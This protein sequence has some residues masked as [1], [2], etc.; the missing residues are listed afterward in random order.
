MNRQTLASVLIAGLFGASAFAASAQ[1]V[2]AVQAEA[3]APTTATADAN[4]PADA[5]KTKPAF[6]NN[7][8][9]YT[10]TRIQQR[11]K[12][13]K[14]VCNP[15]PGRAYSKQDLDRTGE[16]DVADALRKLDPAVY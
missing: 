6:D 2:V 15:G 11:D 14:P 4:A 9:R 12:N 7:C 1:S 5:Q 3:Q 10:G 16:I 8:L 13:G